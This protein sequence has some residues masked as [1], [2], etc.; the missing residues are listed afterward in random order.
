MA[1]EISV[2]AHRAAS[3]R[4]ERTPLMRVLHLTSGNMYGGVES[5]LT[6]LAREM[7]SLVRQYGDV[8]VDRFIEGTEL[9]VG[10]MGT[11]ET[12][13]ALPVLERRKP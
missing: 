1:N 8:L 7:E 11:G 3:R 4:P 10:V 6:T 12:L 2:R 9:T 5:F 13:R